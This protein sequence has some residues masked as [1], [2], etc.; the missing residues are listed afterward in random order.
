MKPEANTAMGK[1]NAQSG[2]TLVEVMIATLL[3]SFGL[4]TFLAAFTAAS[5]TS[6]ATARRIEAVHT[7]RRVMED[8]RSNAYTHQDLAYG[9]NVIEDGI[10]VK[11]TPATDFAATKDI[12]LRVDWNNPGKSEPAQVVIW[13]SMASCIHP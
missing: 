8:L 11:V 3:V 7:A 12:E 13:S 2:M 10:V 6:E 4:G 5:R 1:Q 9:T